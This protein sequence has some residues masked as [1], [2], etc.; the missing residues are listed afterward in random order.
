M[1]GTSRGKVLMFDN[2]LQLRQVVNATGSVAVVH[3]IT[4]L[5]FHED[6]NILLCG[7]DNGCLSLLEASKGSL[8]RAVN[9]MHAASIIK[10]QISSSSEA[11]LDVVAVSVDQAGVVYRFQLKKKIWGL[12][13]ESICLLDGSAG[14]ISDLSVLKTALTCD[15]SSKAHSKELIAFNSTTRTYI[16][17]VVPTI[18]VIYRWLLAF[19]VTNRTADSNIEV[20]AND[21]DAYNICLHWYNNCATD[22]DTGEFLLLRSA[23]SLIE[24]MRCEQKAPS[25]PPTFDVFASFNYSGRS[26]VSCC[27]LDRNVVIFFESEIMVTDTRFM[28]IYKHQTDRQLFKGVD[29]PRALLHSFPNIIT[30]RGQCV[31]VLSDD[32]ICTFEMLSPVLQIE[33]LIKAEKWIQALSI[34]SKHS[35]DPQ[36]QSDLNLR[37][38]AEQYCIFSLKSNTFGIQKVQPIFIAE[39]CI[40]FCVTCSLFDLLFTEIYAHFSDSDAS[41]VFLQAI[42][43]AILSK[44]IKWLPQILLIDLLAHSCQQSR[45]H[46]FENC[47][48]ILN[49]ENIDIDTFSSV[50]LANFMFS[51]YICCHSYCGKFDLTFMSL[52]D[53]AFRV[54]HSEDIKSTIFDKLM[55]FVLFTI[56]K[57]RFPNGDNIIISLDEMFA[58]LT[59]MVEKQV[60][61]ALWEHDSTAFLFCLRKSVEALSP[62]SHSS[63]PCTLQNVFS[64]VVAADESNSNNYGKKAFLDAFVDVVVEFKGDISSIMLDSIL[65]YLSLYHSK[66]KADYYSR[67]LAISQLGITSIAPV[68]RK[69]NFWRA[70]IILE[71]TFEASLFSDGLA[72]YAKFKNEKDV[73]FR[74]QIFDFIDEVSSIVFEGSNTPPTSFFETLSVVLEMLSCISLEKTLILITIYSKAN[75]EAIL[76]LLRLFPDDYKTRFDLIEAVVDHI[77]FESGNEQAITTVFFFKQYFELLSSCKP[78]NCLPF[79]VRFDYKDEYRD[80]IYNIAVSK[81]IYDV[82]VHILEREDSYLLSLDTLQKELL[83][84]LQHNSY[85]REIVSFR[86]APR[87]L[88]AILSSI[89]NIC[90][91]GNKSSGDTS[92]WFTALNGILR[93][94]DEFVSSGDSSTE[95]SDSIDNCLRVLITLMSHELHSSDIVRHLTSKE[96]IGERVFDLSMLFHTMMESLGMDHYLSKIIIQI[97]RADMNDLFIKKRSFNSLGRRILPDKSLAVEISL[98]KSSATTNGVFSKLKRRTLNQITKDAPFCLAPAAVMSVNNTAIPARCPGSLPFKPKFVAECIVGLL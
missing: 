52:F 75:S 17:Q 1:V 45:A 36:I 57:K 13:F 40:E 98:N 14:V 65:S 11:S 39:V 97:Y 20:D 35:I 44:I 56:E 72:Y 47:V 26:I 62:H 10:V 18:E 43:L 70:S 48:I 69:N 23:A 73:T 91:I 86:L 68:F 28:L 76:N 33:R 5:D 71:R 30:C 32:A 92:L 66:S 6:S 12:N 60:V 7:F 82:Q 78:Q 93:M 46:A 2:L 22:S 87:A 96:V 61:S 25:T 63:L 55:L 27:W 19:D 37:L 21:N 49:L 41:S 29:Y 16:V 79:I 9:D 88:D 80:E 83:D 8:I 51:A 50:L 31:Y 89:C 85:N 67:R 59:R 64:V 34:A 15:G 74:D 53:F 94:K 3:S 24:I 81:K 77:E 42:E 84:S 58:L 54:E 4:S 90:N 95:S 38:Y